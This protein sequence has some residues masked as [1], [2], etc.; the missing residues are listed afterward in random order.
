NNCDYLVAASIVID[1]VRTDTVW[2]RGM[3]MARAGE[4]GVPG[5]VAGKAEPALTLANWGAAGGL[6]GSAPAVFAFDRALMTG[7]L[8]P[9]AGLKALWTPEGNGSY[10]ALGQWVFPGRFKGCAA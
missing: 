5:F 8:L 2:P 10:Q 4:V 6:I 9:P 3:A 1:D 7:K